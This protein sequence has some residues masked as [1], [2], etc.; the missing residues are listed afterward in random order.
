MD[1]RYEVF[2]LADRHF[3]ESLDRLS[4]ESIGSGESGDRPTGGV[5]LFETAQRETPPGWRRLRTGDWLHIDPPAGAAA[6]PLQGWKIH[7]SAGLDNADKVAAKV[8]DYC[9]PRGI[10]FKFVPGRQLLH[11]RNS[12]YAGR[13]SS[14]KFVTIYPPDEQALR[15]VLEELGELLDGE[16]GPYILTDL[17]WREGPLYVRYGAFAKRFCVGGRG[18]LVPAVE[19]GEG[20]LVPDDRSPAFRIPSWVTLPGFLAPHL[21]AR[22]ATT[23][24]D[25]PYRIEKALHFS[26]G[27]GVYVGTDTRSGEKVVLKEARPHAGLASDGA[28]AVTR[29]ER[30]ADALRRLTGLGVAPEVRDWFTVGDHSFLV[31]DF[32]EGKSLNSFFGHRHPLLTPDPDPAAVEEFTLWALRIHAG[33]ERAVAAVHSRGVVFN[34]LHMFNIMVGPDEESVTLL[35]FEAAAPA[36]ENGRQAMAHPGFVAPPDR[37]GAEVDRYALACLRLALF[38]PVTTL[39][40]VDRTKAAHLAEVIAGQF[41]VPRGFLDEAVAEITRGAEPPAVPPFVFGAEAPRSAAA[42]YLPADPADWPAARDSMAEAIL[43]S[44]TPDREDRLFPGDIAQFSEGG[45]LGLAHG[46]AGVLYAFAE[47]GLPRYEQGERW[48]LD[49]TE[50]LPNGIPLGLYDGVAGLAYTLE[51]LGHTERALALIRTLL[52]ENWQRLSSDLSGG[53]AGIGLVLD[54]LARTTGETVLRERALEAATLAAGRLA[55]IQEHDTR[56]VRRAGLMRGATGPALLFLRLYE[57]TGAPALLGH[58]ARALHLDLDACVTTASGALEVDEGWRTMPYLGDGSTGIGMVLDDFLGLAPRAAE[59]DLG[60]GAPEGTAARFEQAR[61]DI[62]RAATARL[63]AQPGLLAGRAGMILHLARTT[64]PGVPEVALAEQV[65]ALGWYG[66]SY[67]G[68]L[69]FPGNQMMRLSMDLGTG[70]AGCLLALGAVFGES[71]SR[72]PFLPP[73]SAVGP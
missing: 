68:R 56:T 69:A 26:N 25:L 37:R 65:D 31:M 42:S 54:H 22:N 27:G 50:H 4:A 7:V 2:C 48:L 14:G 55:Q 59:P 73:L 13:D 6:Y 12:K 39:F 60:T 11:L 58:A 63:Y 43:A 19:D 32:V 40:A 8:W 53:L 38:L 29:L 45:G 23:V 70:T 21:A 20:R 3:Y 71:P 61:T 9:V 15:T 30:E 16:P 24:A 51:R 46:A 33:V 34:D 52:A 47:T 1:N 41:P 72:L 44:A 49:R 57:C 64:A 62:V 36:T 66:M 5:S 67:G 17:R 10:P 28:D 18:T 35:D